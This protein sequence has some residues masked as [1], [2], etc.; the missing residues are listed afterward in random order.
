M[1]VCVILSWC[2]GLVSMSVGSG[3]GC[4]IWVLGLGED[5]WMGPSSSLP[6]VDAMN[7][8]TLDSV[9]SG[10]GGGDISGLLGDLHDSGDG[11]R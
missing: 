4:V 2:S 9:T 7:D 10:V 3:S 11:S 6:S 1:S 5:C 8:A